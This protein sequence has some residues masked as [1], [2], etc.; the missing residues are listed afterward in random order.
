M[1][2]SIFSLAAYIWM[3][4]V[5]IMISPNVIEFWEAFLTLLFFPLLVFI[6]WWADH[7]FCVRGRRAS[8]A[9]AAVSAES[10][11]NMDMEEDDGLTIVFNIRTR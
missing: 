8:I 7:K 3:A 5:V 9:D 10:Q 4:V 2:T 1:I 6:S 11:E